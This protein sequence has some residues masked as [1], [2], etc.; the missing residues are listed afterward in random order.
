MV[1][2]QLVSQNTLTH[3]VTDSKCAEPMVIC[4]TRRA[5]QLARMMESARGW[6]AR[7]TVWTYCFL[8]AREASGV[9][10]VVSH[11]EDG[12]QVIGKIVLHPVPS[13][14]APVPRE[15]KGSVALDERVP[16]SG[17][18]VRC[19]AVWACFKSRLQLRQHPDL[20]WS[21]IFSIRCSPFASEE[22]AGERRLPVWGWFDSILQSRESGA[23]QAPVAR[24]AE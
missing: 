21:R 8:P 2:A 24:S 1:A 10:T 19:G 20:S 17:R 9:M 3:N 7:W 11:G 22:R 18:T 16:S 13:S 14:I 15:M 12:P 5:P 4:L 23:D 6:D